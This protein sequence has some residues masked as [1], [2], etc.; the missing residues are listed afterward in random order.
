MPDRRTWLRHK[1]YRLMVA[2]PLCLPGI[3]MAMVGKGHFQ[4]EKMFAIG[5]VLAFLLPLLFVA[6]QDR[7]R[8]E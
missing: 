7:L 8:R 3:A 5:L 2:A 4:S 6:W 1:I